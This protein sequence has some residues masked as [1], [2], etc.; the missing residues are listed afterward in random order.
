MSIRTDLNFQRVICN[1]EPE[2]DDRRDRY[3]GLEG[4]GVEILLQGTE[5]GRGKGQ[6]ERAAGQGERASERGIPQRRNETRAYRYMEGRIRDGFTAAMTF[7]VPKSK[8][9]A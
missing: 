3:Q 8:S 5:K 1:D 9:D 7:T 6:T 2:E 4:G